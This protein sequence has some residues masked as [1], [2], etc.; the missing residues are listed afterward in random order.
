MVAR[1]YGKVS[2]QIFD[3][4]KVGQGHRKQFSQKRHSMANVKIYKTNFLYFR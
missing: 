3:L 1:H 4:Q 2:I